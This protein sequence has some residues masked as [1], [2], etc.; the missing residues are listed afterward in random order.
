VQLAVLRGFA[1][2]ISTPFGSNT[3]QQQQQQQ[4]QQH[5]PNQPSQTANV[6][7]KSR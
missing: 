7:E 2:Q 3:K 4:Q 6:F 1:L 5:K